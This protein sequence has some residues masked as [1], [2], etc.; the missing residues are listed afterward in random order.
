MVGAGTVVRRDEDAAKQWLDSQNR[1]YVRSHM[2]PDNL[3]RLVDT[4]EVRS[5]PLGSSHIFKDVILTL[6]VEE[7]RRRS[8][9]EAVLSDDNEA[10]GLCIRQ[11]TQQ[12]GIDYAED[13]SVRA[14]A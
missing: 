10:F 11:C 3:L 6:P 12:N 9:R 2:Q 7:V 8:R 1:K 4:G 5:P 14:N 13:G